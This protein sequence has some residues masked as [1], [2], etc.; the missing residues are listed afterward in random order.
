MV[1]LTITPKKGESTIAGSRN[2]ALYD[3]QDTP[4]QSCGVSLIDRGSD[5]TD[6]I[7]RGHEWGILVCLANELMNGKHPPEFVPN[8]S[9]WNRVRVAV[10]HDN[11]GLS[12]LG[13]PRIRVVHLLQC[14]S[15]RAIEYR[16]LGKKLGRA[17]VRRK[18]TRNTHKDTQQQTHIHTPRRV[19]G[20]SSS[21]HSWWQCGGGILLPSPRPPILYQFK[22]KKKK[23]I[24]LRKSQCSASVSYVCKSIR[25]C[26]NGPFV[27]CFEH[28]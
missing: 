11:G 27:Q 22:K 19:I 6:L 4:K 3:V 20:V 7:E 21:I 28:E 2:T 5:L 18:T 9:G 14:T 24:M 15:P 16:Q 1:S 13:Q 26:K 25:Y 17:M 23:V 10:V 8:P 12:I